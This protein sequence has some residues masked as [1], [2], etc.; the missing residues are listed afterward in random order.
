VIIKC[1][2]VVIRTED[3]DKVREIYSMGLDVKRKTAVKDSAGLYSAPG[4]LRGK[5]IEIL[6]AAGYAIEI[7]REVSV[8]RL[9]RHAY[10]EASM[11]DVSTRTIGPEASPHNHELVL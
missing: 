1:F 4:F 5:D 8:I 10:V 9:K 7:I 2:E 3:W 11:I 6:V